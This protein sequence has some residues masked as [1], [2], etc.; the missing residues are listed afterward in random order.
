[1][2][3]RQIFE[4]RRRAQSGPVSLGAAEDTPRSLGVVALAER[5]NL[6]LRLSESLLRRHELRA[7]HDL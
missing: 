7:R 4:T 2:L 1:M 3:A 5:G 6:L